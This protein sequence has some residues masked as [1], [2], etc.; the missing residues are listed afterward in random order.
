MSVIRLFRGSGNR[1][2]HHKGQSKDQFKQLLAPHIEVMYRM[3]YRWTQSQADAED[4]VQDV[5]VR[6]AT[7]LEEMQAINDLKPWLLKVLYHRF[8]D[9][10]RSQKVSPLVGADT[11]SADYDPDSRS[12]TPTDPFANQPAPTNNLTQMELR[13]ALLHAIYQLEPDQTDVVLLHDL[14]GYTAVEVAEI[15]DTSVG[16]VK[17]RLHR[18]RE[19]LK[20]LL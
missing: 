9:L 16:T 18:A 17:S 7:R 3:A 10:Y 20:K 8:V 11:L 14:E 15:M 6:L 19:K 2:G 12:E 5:L 4:L 1:K 13:D